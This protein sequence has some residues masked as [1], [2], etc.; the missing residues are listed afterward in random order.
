LVKN[1]IDLDDFINNLIK[2]HFKNDLN[3]I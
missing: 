1:I 2:D 3:L